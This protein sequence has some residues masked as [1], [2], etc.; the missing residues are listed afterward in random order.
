VLDAD[1]DF[2]WIEA[3]MKKMIFAAFAAAAVVATGCVETVSGTHT[4]A[5]T[6]GKDTMSGRYQR[7]I[8]QVYQAS[9]AVIQQNG[10]LVTEFIPHD[11]TNAVRSLEGRVNER[12]V[13]VRVEAVDPRITAVDVEARTTW[14]SRDLDLSHELEKEIA[15]Q[16]AR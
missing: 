11:S 14:G 4:F 15:L 16:L 12:N 6:I 9:V 3:D 2:S 1:A 13:W 8:D 7:T 5:S 10:V